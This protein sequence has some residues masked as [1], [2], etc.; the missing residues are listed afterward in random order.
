[1]NNPQFTQTFKRRSKI[2]GLLETVTQ[3]KTTQQ[4]KSDIRKDCSAKV[5]K[6]RIWGVETGKFLGSW[7][8][9]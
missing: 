9:S 6:S 8:I 4:V 7:D 5:K 2:T 3:T 1:M